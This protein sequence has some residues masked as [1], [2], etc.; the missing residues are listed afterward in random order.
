MLKYLDPRVLARNSME[1][2]R[3]EV[4]DIEA[5]WAGYGNVNLLQIWSAGWLLR[6][7]GHYR[8]LDVVLGG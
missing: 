4:R 5:R 3:F 7:F 8:H 2:A 1:R 6:G